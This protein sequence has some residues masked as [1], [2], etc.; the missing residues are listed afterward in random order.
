MSSTSSLTTSA[1]LVLFGA[2][3]SATI[4]AIRQQQTKKAKKST[5]AGIV[6]AQLRKF[7]ITLPVPPTPK[8]N[9]VSCT[10]QGNVLYICGHIPT[11]F[12]TGSLITGKVGKD[13]TVEE[14]YASA[15]ACAINILGTLAV[16]LNGNLDSIKRIV[17][18]VG[19]VNCTDDF[20]QQPAVV[21]GA[22]DLFGDVFGDKGKHAR[23]AVGTNSLPLN[24]ATEVECIVEIED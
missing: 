21:N 18:V 1:S 19:F 15:K 20:T 6:Q 5:N 17:K 22:S 3:A 2:L 24:I 12:E 23:S 10:R 13:L 7:G 11:D 16:E 14:G 8:G 4:I 9:Y